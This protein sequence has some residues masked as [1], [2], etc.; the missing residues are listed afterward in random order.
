MAV[1]ISNTRINLSRQPA[2]RCLSAQQTERIRG[3]HPGDELLVTRGVIWVTQKGDLE[4]HL[5]RKGEKYTVQRKGDVVVQAL[6]DA[7]CYFARG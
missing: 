5:I 6:S 2:E 1:Q 7:A 3:V 4:D